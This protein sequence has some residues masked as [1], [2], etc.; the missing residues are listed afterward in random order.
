MK[1]TIHCGHSCRSQR[2]KNK[3]GVQDKD[4]PHEY[5]EEVY[6]KTKTYHMNMLKKYIAIKSKVDVVHTSNKNDATITKAGVICQDTDPEL[7]EVPDL[8]C[9]H[10]KEG[11]RDVKL[12][13]DLSKDQLH[14]LKDLIQRYP[15]VFTDMPGETGVIQHKVKLTDDTPICCKPYSLPYATREE[16]RNEVYSMLEMGVVKPSTSPY[17]SPIVMVKKKM[18]LTGC[19]L[20]SES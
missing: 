16:L 12:G 17:A 13:E 7:V 19:V 3:D 1:R 6:C 9:Y 8:E 2:L 10:Q 20:T 18:V 11:V 4:A 15:D 14:M 5:V